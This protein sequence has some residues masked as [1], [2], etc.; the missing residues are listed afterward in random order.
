[1]FLSNLIKKNPAFLPVEACQSDYSLPDR[2]SAFQLCV[3]N[4][5]QTVGVQS[6]TENNLRSAYIR[7]PKH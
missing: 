4:M 7:S 5:Y 1:M 6:D 3:L 2:E